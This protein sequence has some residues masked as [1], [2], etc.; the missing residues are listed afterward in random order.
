MGLIVF[1]AAPRDAARKLSMVMIEERVAACVNV[2]DKVSSYFR[3]QGKIE[4]AEESLLIIKT[5]SELFDRLKR[6]VE[7]N[8]PYDIPEIAAINIERVN[9]KYLN[10]LRSEVNG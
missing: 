9:R 10:W 4:T 2:I 6:V 7:K 5:T 1:V 3:W 8:H